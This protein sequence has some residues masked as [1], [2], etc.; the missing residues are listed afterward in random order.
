VLEEGLSPVW[1]ITIDGGKPWM[2]DELARNELPLI[3]I[4]VTPTMISSLSL[5][6]AIKD[7][8]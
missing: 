6:L 3:L 2:M 7:L 8:L 1:M 4:D 5:V